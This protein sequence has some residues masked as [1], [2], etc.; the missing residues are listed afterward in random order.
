VRLTV[1]DALNRTATVEHDVVVG[2][3]ASSS[4]VAPSNTSRPVVSGSA[5]Q[6]STLSANS[7]AWSGDAP[8]TYAYQWQQD[9]TS[10]IAGATGST[11]VVQGSDVGH[12]L[13]VVVTASNGAGSQKAASAATGA[14]VA[15]GGGSSGG[16]SGSGG[17]VSPTCDLNA[18][19]ATFASQVSAA[20]PGQTICLASGNYGTFNGAA[21][22]GP[23]YVT[24]QPA[25]GASATMAL[26]WSGSSFVKVD[27]VT[28]TSATVS[29]AT[30][31]VTVADSTFTGQ[32]DV[33]ATHMSNANVVF[34]HNT[35]NNV[36][37]SGGRIQV[38][39][40]GSPSSPVGVTIENSMFSG[41]DADGVQLLGGEYGT[42]I[43]NNTFTRLDD[44]ATGDG[45]HTDAIQVYGGTHDVVKGNFFYN[46]QNMAS[47]SFAEWDGGSSMLFEN[48]VVAG[49][50]TNGCYDGIDL[51]DDHSSQ[52]IH[53]VFAYGAC[54]PNGASSPCG[55]IALGG[56]SSEGAGSGTLIRDNVYTSLTN[57]N[58]GL[59]ATFSENHNLYRSGTGGTGDIKGTPTFVGGAN[60]TTFAGF[61]LASGSAG[62]GA[63]SDGTNIG[64]ELPTG[65]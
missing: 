39:G 44:G 14:V 7:G 23:G 22:A 53:N 54:F 4:G 18:T 21:K 65:G 56:K 48:N 16:G 3:A 64:I 41:G 6:G 47:C 52:V 5:Q 61:A 63:A 46:Q 34:D 40:N 30:H 35:H 1:T 19:T 62:I 49:T 27:G 28:I 20:Q 50:P 31:D 26:N 57:G 60:P 10:N 43:L 25:S 13:D 55:N 24:I 15:S 38:W 8:M 36:S 51:Y 29:G 58:G 11:Y 42:Q 33:E 32:L 17:G 12:T 59:N 45:N 2:S 9:G 37:L